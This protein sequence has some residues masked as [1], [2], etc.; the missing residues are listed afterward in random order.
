MQKTW[1]YRTQLPLQFK[2][3]KDIWSDQ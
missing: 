3:T 1:Y 2:S